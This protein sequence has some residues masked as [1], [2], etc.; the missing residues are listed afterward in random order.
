MLS[1]FSRQPL[2]P[3]VTLKKYVVAKPAQPHK[4]DRINNDYGNYWTRLDGRTVTVVYDAWVDGA[5]AYG[6]LTI[7]GGHVQN[8]TPKIG[9]NSAH[10]L[11][12]D[13]IKAKAEAWINAEIHSRQTFGF[14]AIAPQGS[15]I[16]IQAAE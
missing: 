14:H 8:H 9:T 4:S 7:A 16:S 1:F 2:P 15:E 10:S 13:D 3:L 11:I 12:A 6:K 5:K